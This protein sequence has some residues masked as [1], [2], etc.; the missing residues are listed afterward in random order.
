[1]DLKRELSVFCRFSHSIQRSRFGGTNLHIPTAEITE[2]GGGGTGALRH[3]IRRHAAAHMIRRS[4]LFEICVRVCPF[5]WT[6]LPGQGL[7][8]R[9]RVGLS[10]EQQTIL[11][12]DAR[13][14]RGYEYSLP[15]V[16]P[17]LTPMCA[18]K[19]AYTGH[20]RPQRPCPLAGIDGAIDRSEVA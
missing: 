6:A 7:H 14:W 19:S 1:M 17:N 15:Q 16:P 11:E 20:I 18:R 3:I 9:L 13:T 2:P 4:S 10:H 5:H 12:V 8:S